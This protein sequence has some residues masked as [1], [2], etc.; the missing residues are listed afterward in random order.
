MLAVLWRIVVSV[1]NDGLVLAA[2]DKAQKV[3]HYTFGMQ[4]QP[5]MLQYHSCSDSPV[6]AALVPA[7]GKRQQQEKQKL[8]FTMF[9]YGCTC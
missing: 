8:S 5:L 9:E 6:R 3:A 7:H 2:A 1:S 4:W